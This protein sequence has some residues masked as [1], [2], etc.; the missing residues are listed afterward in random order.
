MSRF[1][2]D[3]AFSYGQLVYLI[4][5]SEQ[6]ARIVVKHILYPDHTIMYG[7]ACGT[8]YSEHYEIEIAK[9]RNIMITL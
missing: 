2:Y 6:R 1:A 9:D 8:L 7:L 5:D 4:T 3:A